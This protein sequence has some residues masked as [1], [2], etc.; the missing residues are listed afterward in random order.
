MIAPTVNQPRPRLNIRV[1][2]ALDGYLF[3]APAVLGFL[4]F[5]LLPM[6]ASLWLGFT[7]YDLLSAPQWI[8]LGNYTTMFADPFFWQSLR[9][10]AVYALFSLPL[11]LAA[12][13]GIALLMNQRVPAIAFWRTI[14]VVPSVISGVAVAVLWRWLFNPEFG[15]VNLLLGLLGVKG[16]NWLGSADWALPSLIIMGLW[17]IG[18]SMLIYLAGLQGIPTDLYEAVGIDGGAAWTKFRH[19]TLPLLSPVILFNLVVGLIGAFQYFTEAYV[20]TKGGP[21]NATLFYTLYLYRNA[22]NYFQMGYAAA[23]A[24]MLFLLVLV[25]TLA[26]FKSTPMWVYYEGERGKR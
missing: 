16:P 26:V 19:V 20:L 1:R 24:W 15:L 25:L 4:L 2:E 6:L 23:L 8:G 12:A 10:T 5:T 7:E 3:M 21:E 9:V 14:Y 11:G 22:F 18:G 17:G 13:L